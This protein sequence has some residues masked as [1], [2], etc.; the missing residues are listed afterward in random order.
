[1]K[2]NII[3]ADQRFTDGVEQLS[4]LLGITT[5]EDGIPV[6]LEKA[7]RGLSFFPDGEGYKVRYNRAV[8]FYRALGLLVEGLKSGKTVNVSQTPHFEANGL[9]LDNSRNAVQ[10]VPTIKRM[11][12]YL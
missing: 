10:T 3:G 11:L 6:R 12:R 7:G 4:D 9:M 2:L 5:G 8:E 1:M